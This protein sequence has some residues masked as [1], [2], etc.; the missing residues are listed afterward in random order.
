MI[1]P[2]RQHYERDGVWYDVPRPDPLAVVVRG[3][4]LNALAY[5]DG[6]KAEAA[7]LL[8]VT[9]RTLVYQMRVYGIPATD[10]RP[11]RVATGQPP[12][13]RRGAGLQ[14]S[15]LKKRLKLVAKAGAA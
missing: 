5:S 8:N 2:E 7:T 10:E 13:K 9:M 1:S 14:V 15:R 6:V 3:A 11:G 12:R 4:I